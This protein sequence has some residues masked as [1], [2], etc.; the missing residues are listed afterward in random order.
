MSKSQLFILRISIMKRMFH[1][2]E[3]DFIFLFIF[4]CFFSSKTSDTQKFWPGENILLV[5]L[6]G[7]G[8]N[9]YSIE[10]KVESI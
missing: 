4:A 3:T 6:T 5:R 8:A 7:L 10:K 1:N 9:A 2:K